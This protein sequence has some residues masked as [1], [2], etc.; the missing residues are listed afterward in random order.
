MDSEVA[1]QVAGPPYGNIREMIITE[2]C[3][4]CPR[5][6]SLQH[7]AYRFSGCGFRKKGNRLRLGRAPPRFLVKVSAEENGG[8]PQTVLDRNSGRNPVHVTLQLNIHENQVR[9]MLRCPIHRFTP[10]C[11][12]RDNAVPK[13]LQYASYC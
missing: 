12:C 10:G 1:K 8:D 2:L 13:L 7:F 11:H 6:D 3:L 5:F 9:P 4:P